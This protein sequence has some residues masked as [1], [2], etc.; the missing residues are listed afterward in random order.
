MLAFLILMIV[1]FMV[2]RETIAKNLKDTQFIER[3]LNKKP[4]EK[5]PAPEKPATPEKPAAQQPARPE[6]TSTP[7]KNDA[8]AT[9][10]EKPAADMP[11][12]QPKPAE[13]PPQKTAPKDVPAAKPAPEKP[14]ANTRERMLWYVR[15]DNDGVIA[16]V[17]VRRPLPTT[18]S[19][20]VDAI[21]ALL[22]GPT[23]AESK[24]GYSSLI[25]AG[26]KLLSATVRGTTAYLS[27]NDAFQFNPYGIEGYAAQL[28][29][30]VWTATEFDTVADVQ[31]LIE[32]RR[33][34]YL[35]AEGIVIGVPLTRSSLERP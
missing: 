26:T 17:G 15:I 8:P 30:I 11:K 14:A 35:G 5:T 29:Q 23:A 33:V 10:P 12:E 32:G 9:A 6:G 2:N 34:D 20:L 24:K 18:D 7:A 3:I 28:R 13:A 16:R 21:G 31:I 27:F 4:A 19:P 25:P 22:K 1:L